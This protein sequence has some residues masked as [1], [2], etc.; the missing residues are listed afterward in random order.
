MT[1]DDFYDYLLNLCDKLSHET[2]EQAETID[3]LQNDLNQASNEIKLLNLLSFGFIT[4]ISSA[5]SINSESNIFSFVIFKSDNLLSLL[6]CIIFQ[7]FDKSIFIF[8]YGGILLIIL[9]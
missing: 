1:F 2:D 6:L 5:L 7:Y 3:E 8:L 9:V 4:F